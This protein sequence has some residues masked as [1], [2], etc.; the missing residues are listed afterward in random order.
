MHEH[1]A[2]VQPPTTVAEALR[3]AEAARA[4]QERRTRVG[5]NAEGDADDGREYFD[6]V[7]TA[8]LPGAVDGDDGGGGPPAAQGA[9]GEGR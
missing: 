6:Y 5:L 2:E 9:R 8:K 1:V 3:R 4:E 7:A